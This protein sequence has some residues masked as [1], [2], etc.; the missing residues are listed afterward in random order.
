[1][2]ISSK[3]ILTFS[4]LFLSGLVCL[5]ILNVF[6]SANLNEDIQAKYYYCYNYPDKMVWHDEVLAL[7][8]KEG[9]RVIRRHVKQRLYKTYDHHSKIITIYYIT[10]DNWYRIFKLDLS[11]KP[12]QLLSGYG[13]HTTYKDFR[14]SFKTATEENIARYNKNP[15]LIKYLPEKPLEKDFSYAF[16]KKNLNCKTLNYASYL[17]YLTKITLIR[18]LSA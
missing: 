4:V 14:K 3:K 13:N 8:K 9:A 17:F 2:S 5:S 18:A 16:L 15:E 11:S 7:E 12:I 10:P 1:M 6:A